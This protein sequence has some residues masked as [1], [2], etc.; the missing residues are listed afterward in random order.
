MRLASSSASLTTYCSTAARRVSHVVRIHFRLREYRNPL[1]KPA[2][3][4]AQ[5]NL[6]VTYQACRCKN[7][8]PQACD[9]RRNNVSPFSKQ[10]ALLLLSKPGRQVSSRQKIASQNPFSML[11]VST[12]YAQMI[13]DGMSKGIHANRV[14][15]TMQRM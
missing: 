3:L 12:A 11:V 7:D 13:D 5:Q 14:K 9:M 8:S 15:I 2:R 6:T 4:T 10:L 1:S